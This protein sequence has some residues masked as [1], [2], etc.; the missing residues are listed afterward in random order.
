V[1]EDVYYKKTLVFKAWKQSLQFNTS[2]ELFSSHDIDTGTRQLL[3]TVAASDLPDFK[4]VL[5]LG[6]GYGPLGLTLKALHPSSEVH[7]VDKDALALEYSRQNAALNKLESVQVYGSLGYDEIRASDFDLI[8]SNIPGKAGTPVITYLLREASGYLSPGG[9]VAVVVVSPLD[10][11][12]SRILYETPGIEVLLKREWA[13]H[14]VFHYRCTQMETPI[15]Q[16]SAVERGIYQRESIAFHYGK[17][18]YPMHTAFGLPDFDSLGNENEL[19]F[20]TFKQLPRRVYSHMLLYNSGQGH[21][22][23]VAGS[24]L[25]IDHLTVVDRDLLALKVTRLNLALNNYPPENL[26]TIHRLGLPSQ[27]DRVD[28][29][30]IALREEEGPAA[31]L[32]DLRNLNLCLAPEGLAL[33]TSGSTA[34]TR[35]VENLKKE[36]IFLVQAR[37]RWRGQSLLILRNR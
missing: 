5:D 12:V 7:L 17:I 28:L 6:C 16:I 37:D 35:L 8:M 10:P 1:N 30:V 32:A 15:P 2:Q 34:I 18:E 31:N 14:T 11:E 20:H 26:N 4:K 33:V 19:L 25:K 24:Q 21:I 29:A 22:A 3:R 13:E 23:I 27:L 36:K 9:R